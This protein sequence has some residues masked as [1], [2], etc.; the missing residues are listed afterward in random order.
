MLLH[1]KGRRRHQGHMGSM[2]QSPQKCVGRHQGLS[3]SNVALEKPVHRTGKNQILINLPTNPV[4]ISGHRPGQCFSPRINQIPDFFRSLDTDRLPR[5]PPDTQGELHA[6]QFFVGQS[7]S[8]PLHFFQ[9]FRKVKYPPSL[10]ATRQITLGRKSFGHFW[11][12]DF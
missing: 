2:F 1:Q 7:S 11:G 8:C 6:D 12:T 4:L 10:R 9:R 5:R 3:G